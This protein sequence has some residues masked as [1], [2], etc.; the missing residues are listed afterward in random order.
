[1]SSFHIINDVTNIHDALPFY[2]PY[3]S[4][5]RIVYIQFELCIYIV[6][7]LIQICLSVPWCRT[8]SMD[9]NS[10]SPGTH[11]WKNSLV[12]VLGLCH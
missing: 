10:S 8:A 11:C 6:A 1:M 3:M 12:C 9:P 2:L 7:V 5:S 4:N